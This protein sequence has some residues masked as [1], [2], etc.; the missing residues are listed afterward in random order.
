MNLSNAAALMASLGWRMVKLHGV[1]RRPDGSAC[2][3]CHKAADCPSP[4]KHPVAKDWKTEASC[5]E[6][7]IAEWFDGGTPWNVGLL[8]GPGSG[9]IDVEF[10]GEDG[11]RYAEE[12]GLDRIATP[13]YRSSRSVHRLFRWTSDL[14]PVAVRKVRGLEVRIGGGGMSAQSVLPPSVHHSG[15]VYSWLPTLGP[16]EV[17]LAPLPEPLALALWNGDAAAPAG[18]GGEMTMTRRPPA[19]AILDTGAAEGGRNDTLYRYAVS[20]VFRLR[21]P[22]SP[23][24]Q[25]DFHDTV[26]AVNMTKCKPPLSEDEVRTICA[27]ALA[28]RRKAD[29]QGLATQAAVEKAVADGPPGA[30][31]ERAKSERARELVGGLNKLTRHGLAYQPPRDDPDASPEWWP[32]EWALT[33]VHSDPMVYRLTVPAWAPLTRD[34]NGTVDLTVTQY[35]EPAAVASAVLTRT[36]RICL[37]EV[38]GLWES[39]WNGKGGKAAGKGAPAQRPTRGLKAK[40]LDV[41]DDLYPGASSLRYATVA[42]FLYEE[43]QRSDPPEDPDE[44]NPRGTPRWRMDGTLWFAWSRVWEDVD[45]R[46]HKGITE[47]ERLATKRNLLASF[48]EP[49]FRHVR[50]RHPDGTRRVYVVWTSRHLHLLEKLAT[51][52]APEADGGDG[53]APVPAEVS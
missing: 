25:V 28:F 52:K 44:P 42:G 2:C 39:I 34:G 30:K 51:G 29:A 10:D 53:S 5:D 26:A 50:Y 31:D 3:T 13:T 33:I 12:L 4:G 36:G 6:E 19:R 22:S 23:Q 27:S 8:L 45:R 21:D 16:D 47:G 48:G 7:V 40:L 17:T 37:N 41:A 11:E 32:G 24:D 20:Q 9:I 49:D 35:E 46:G 15:A 18:G 1:T 43:L 14:P 38:P